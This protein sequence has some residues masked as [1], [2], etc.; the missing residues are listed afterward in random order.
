MGSITEAELD[1]I[2]NILDMIREEAKTETWHNERWSLFIRRMRL[3]NPQAYGSRIQNYLFD[4]LGWERVPSRLDRGDVRNSPGQY[5]EVKMSFITPK[6]QEVNIVQVRPWQQISGHHIFV[7]D[8]TDHYALYHFGLSKN[9]MGAEIS[10][11]GS[12]AHGTTSAVRNNINREYR[13]GIPWRENHPAY[14][15]WISQY[16]QI[17]TYGALLTERDK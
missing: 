7:V 16:L 3:L 15:R 4:K 9:E 10:L 8:A 13:L 17:H 12:S 2:I 6:N 14:Q 11:I 5:F 1:K